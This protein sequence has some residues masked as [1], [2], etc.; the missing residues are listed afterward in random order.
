M[1]T[2]EIYGCEVCGNEYRSAAE[3]LECEATEETPLAEVGDIVFAKAGYGWYDGLKSWVS[4]AHLP[5]AAQGRRANP[6]HGN[7]FADCCT[8]RFYYVVTKI[9]TDDRDYGQIGEKH[10]VRYHLF[11]LA[12]TG[13]QGHRNGFTFA[14]QHIPPEKV[15]NPPRAVVRGSKKL[16]GQAARHLL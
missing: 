16:L 4:N 11:T 13:K 10:R 3:A 6:E 1:K 14:E 2:I 5:P 12:M 7:C 9:D 15:E 8:Y